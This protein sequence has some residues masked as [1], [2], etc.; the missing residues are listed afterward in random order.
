MYRS[1]SLLSL[2]CAVFVSLTFFTGGVNAQKSKTPTKKPT[3]AKP[4]AQKSDAK[5]DSKS[6]KNKASDKQSDKR[7]AATSREKAKNERDNAKSRKEE[8]ARKSKEDLAR[9]DADKKQDKKAADKKQNKKEDKLELAKRR[10]AEQREAEERREQARREAERRAA[11]EAENRRREQ[12]RREAIARARAFEKGL[13]DETV[14]NI[15]ADDLTGEDMEVRRAA[16]NALGNRAG[17]VVVMDAQNGRVVSIVNQ[18]WA[19]RKGF[20]PCS[21]VKLV[22]GVAGINEH[23]IDANGNNGS[24]SPMDLT[25]ALAYSNN[26]YFQQVS[27]KVGFPKM[28]NYARELGLGAQTGINLPNESTGKLPEPKSGFA[29]NRMGSHGDDFEVTPLQLATMVSALSNGGNVVTPKV[30][31]TQQEAVSFQPKFRRQLNLPQTTL[32]GVQPGMMGAV[33]YGTARRAADTSLN[34]GG[35]TGSCIGQGSWLGLFASVAPVANPKYAVVV[36]TRGQNERGKWASAVAGKVYQALASRIRANAPPLPMLANTA[37]LVTP[38]K[39]KIDPNTAARLS[40]EEKEEEETNG[41][42]VVAGGDFA[43]GKSEGKSGKF[44]PR[45]SNSG[46]VVTSAMPNTSG[47]KVKTTN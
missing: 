35:K 3:A 42:A 23:V 4:A 29:L 33:G 11:I 26:G 17:T 1:F 44:E 9:K 22:T 5:S 13:R 37:P 12:A 27:G 19:V 8:L 46:V 41:E 34:I 15:M 6:A 30:A 36:V 24:R 28:M 47:N 32:R 10:E 38:P 40:D 21:T 45:P 14:N 18:D 7:A 43:N 39:P 20:K 2:V 31:R 16:I 25:D